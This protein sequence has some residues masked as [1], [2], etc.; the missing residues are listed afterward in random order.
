MWG[1][2]NLKGCAGTS[3]LAR[4]GAFS[5]SDCGH[6]HPGRW[7]EGELHGHR[8]RKNVGPT[9]NDKCTCTLV[10]FP[11]VGLS[12]P[13]LQC[14]N[15]ND[16]RNMVRVLSSCWARLFSPPAHHQSRC[17]AG[18]TSSQ[19]TPPAPRMQH[20]KH[21]KNESAEKVEYDKHDKKING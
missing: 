4:F 15:S 14:Q 8:R 11:G 13:H 1:Q 6:A 20:G 19:S 2:S 16:L 10:A 9:C 3:F 21:P 17:P 18:R 7:S 12:L 5:S